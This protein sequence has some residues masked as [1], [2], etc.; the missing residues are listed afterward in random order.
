MDAVGLHRTSPLGWAALL[1]AAT[2]CA[3]RADV[4]WRAGAAAARA[5]AVA[6]GLLALALAFVVW[7][8]RAPLA[9]LRGA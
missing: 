2:A 8:D 7:V 6:C 3:W 5:G 9:R 1:G 4:L